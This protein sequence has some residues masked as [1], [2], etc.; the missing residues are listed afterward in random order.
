MSQT[1]EVTVKEFSVTKCVD[2]KS[3][4]EVPAKFKP[5]AAAALKNVSVDPPKGK[6]LGAYS[7]DVTVEI[8]MVPKG[9]RAEVKIIISDQEPYSKKDKVVAT[10]SGGA[11][12]ETTNPKKGDTDAAVE[13]A[14]DQA[15]KTVI[16]GIKDDA[17]KP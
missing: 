2:P 7:I 6:T 4:T 8:K 1:I 5:K 16:K 3:K 15:L 17:K 12:A 10:A 11:T 14:L 13:A 9:V